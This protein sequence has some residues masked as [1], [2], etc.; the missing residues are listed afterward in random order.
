MKV[1][2]FLLIIYPLFYILSCA[3]FA[4]GVF[5]S[6]LDAFLG[7]EINYRGLLAIVLIIL[8]WSFISFK[9][10]ALWWQTFLGALLS[11][12]AILAI[13]LFLFSLVLFRNLLSPDRYQVEIMYILLLCGISVFLYFGSNK[14]SK[15]KLLK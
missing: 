8:F 9:A 3:F 6:C 14:I 15:S 4:V 1:K 11:S 2:E 7:N 10:E 13:M 5:Y 12:S